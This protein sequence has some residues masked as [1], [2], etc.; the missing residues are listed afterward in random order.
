MHSRAER[1]WGEE[2]Q[3]H[4]KKDLELSDLPSNKPKGIYEMKMAAFI[5]RQMEGGE[6]LKYR[7]KTER[8]TCG[9]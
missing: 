4:K 9:K 6:S 7:K 5:K 3:R 2:K 1:D 8:E